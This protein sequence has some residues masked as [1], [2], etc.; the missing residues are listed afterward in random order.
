MSVNP[1]VVKLTDQRAA[2][3][4]SEI[5]ELHALITAA[6]CALLVKI[7]EFDARLRPARSAAPHQAR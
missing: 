6:T 3:L 1:P 4:G 2:K 5:T 7:R